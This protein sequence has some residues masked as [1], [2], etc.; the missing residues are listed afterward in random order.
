MKPPNEKQAASRIGELLADLLGSSPTEVQVDHIGL[1]DQRYDYAI[2]IGSRR[3]TAKYQGT[4]STAAVASAIDHLQHLAK[5]RATEGDPL[6][7]VPFM[8]PVGQQLCDKSKTS[9]LDLCG[10]AKIVAPGLRVWIEGRPNQYRDRGRPPQYL[11]PQKFPDRKATP[12]SSANLPV[13]AGA[14]QPMTRP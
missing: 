13:N 10:N 9:W 3:F 5:S 14:S 11:R 8:G 6:V 2:S 12:T 7:I 1:T 4:A